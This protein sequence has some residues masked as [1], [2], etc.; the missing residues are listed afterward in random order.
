MKHFTVLQL[1]WMGMPISG[2]LLGLSALSLMVV[3][4]RLW[5]LKRELGRGALLLR[6]AG[7]L[8]GR[9]SVARLAAVAQEG[10]SPAARVLSALFC[11][12]REDAQN[13]L[14]MELNRE[15]SN[16]ERGLQGLATVASVAPYVGLLGTCI[17]VI[18][19]F[20]MISVGAGAGP[21]VVAGGISEALVNT[22]LGLFVAIPAVVAYNLMAASVNRHLRE[23]AWV[24]QAALSHLGQDSPALEA[25]TVVPFPAGRV[26]APAPEPPAAPRPVSNQPSPTPA[27]PAEID[28]VMRPSFDRPTQVQPGGWRGF[29]ESSDPP[30]D[31]L[32]YLDA[33]GWSAPQKREG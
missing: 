2:V 14:G 28:P 25:A 26:V 19:A 27:S 17:G 18:K 15:R 20:D 1:I 23:V 10:N 13:M 8:Q 12:G 30:P 5:V 4:E 6:M 7:R 21:A 33:D 32:A 9:E 29:T 11:L 31:Q 24:A 3:L 22:A 16:L